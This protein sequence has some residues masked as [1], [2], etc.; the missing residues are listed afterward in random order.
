MPFTVSFDFV[1]G[2]KMMTELEGSLDMRTY[3]FEFVKRSIPLICDTN[4]IVLPG[5]FI[6]MEAIMERIPYDL[7]DANAVVKLIIN[8]GNGM[9]QTSRLA[10]RGG[11][12][13]LN[14]HNHSSNNELHIWKGKLL[15]IVDLRSLGYAHLSQEMIY[16]LLE[17]RFVMYNDQGKVMTASVISDLKEEDEEDLENS[18]III[19]PK[20]QELIESTKQEQARR[21]EL[22]K[23]EGDK[24]PWLDEDDPR[25][26][27]TD[28]EIIIQYINLDDSRLTELEKKRF[29][30]ILLKY[31]EAFSLRDEIGLC[32]NMEIKLRM[33]DKTPFF[34]RPFPITED[35]KVIVD[36]EMR[37]G[38]ML[39]IL[40]KGLSSY[41][42][43]IMLIP[44]KL[45]GTPR[46]VTD[47]RHLN[48]RLTRLNCTFP[49]VRDAIQMLGSS[50]CEVVSVIDLRDAYHT[51]RLAKDSQQYCGITPY[52][53][54]DT[55]IYQRLGMGLNVSPAI[56]QTFINQVLDEIED[57]KHHLAIMDDCMIHS[58]KKTHIKHLVNLFKALIRNGLKI[59]P[60]KCQFFKTE[61]V[62]MGQQLLIRDKTPCI[63]PLR[64]RVEA[65]QRVEAPTTVKGCRSFCG[66][67]NYLS[68]YLPNLQKRLIPIYQLTRKGVPYLWTEECQKAFEGIKQDLM[69][70]PVLV[71]PNNRDPFC[72]VSDTSIEAAGAA[73][74]QKQNEV[75]KLVGYNSKKLPGA[76]ARYSI[77]ELELM[78]LAINVHS[79]KHLLK[80]TCFMVIIDHSALTYI[81]K[82]K[83]EPPTLRLKKLIEILMGFSFNVYFM[84]GKDMHVSDFLSRHPGDDK[85]PDNEIIPISFSMEEV[86]TNRQ[87]L[88]RIKAILADPKALEDVFMTALPMTLRSRGPGAKIYPLQGDKRKPEHTPLVLDTSKDGNTPN[89]V[90]PEKTGQELIEKMI[91]FEDEV[92]EKR[93]DLVIRREPVEADKVPDLP[94]APPMPPLPEEPSTKDEQPP[95]AALPQGQDA[96]PYAPP[97]AREEAEELV[98]KEQAKNGQQSS[99]KEPRPIDIRLVGHLPYPN[100]YEDLED[101]PYVRDPDPYMYRKCKSL[102]ENIRDED[103][104]R[105]HIPKQMELDKWMEKLKRKVLHSYQLPITLVELI[106]EYSDSPRFRDYYKYLTKDFIPSGI[107]G[108]ALKK[109]KAKCEDF[110]IIQG[111]MFHLIPGKGKDE[112]PKLL[113]VIPERVVPIIFYQYHDSILAGHQGLQRTY[114]TLKQLYYIHDL[115]QLLRKYIQACHVCQ[116]RRPAPDMPKA[117]Y[118]RYPINCRPMS[119]I[120]ADLKWMPQSAQLM[121]YILVCT[122]E[123]TGY[124]I[125][126]PLR[127]GKAVTIAEALLNRVVYIFGPPSTLIIDQD[128]ALSADVMLNL[129]RILDINTRV[130]SPGNH[131]SL[132]TERSIRSI[133]DIVSKYLTGLGKNWP[134]YVAAACYAHNTFVNP[135]IGYSPY[136]LV[137]MHKPAPLTSIYHDPLED[138][139]STPN[140]AEFVTI[141]K[142]RFEVMKEVM[143]TQRTLQQ[144]Q[145]VERQRLE[146]PTIPNFKV[147]D[148]VYLYA[149]GYGALVFPSRKI[150]QD[151][152]GPLQIAAVIDKTHYWLADKEGKL[153]PFLHTTVHVRDLKPCY[154]HI[155]GSDKK[156]IATISNAKDFIHEKRRF[157][158][159]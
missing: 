41:S 7:H 97:P 49:L 29:R 147:G 103:I 121:Q 150:R 79:F 47:F 88:F 120:S 38:V 43:P 34:I 111:L 135:Q 40:R 60:K 35:E 153:L 117:E 93:P 5:K 71:M 148:L 155:P 22:M 63:T 37:K 54:S 31:R 65:L 123:L 85:C 143:Q 84:K 59:S 145:Q 102:L 86:I 98:E 116:T 56:W 32:P 77:S 24:Y 15:G 18:K 139:P 94:P 109:F 69:N 27:L 127:D 68:M 61:L 6:K 3:Q 72:L 83:K 10:L 125:G 156:E 39:G 4:G 100:D 23:H 122:C 101:K 140:V 78:G 45:G 8:R 107:K 159:P 151:Y 146:H 90:Q 67:V 55:Y 64:T 1:V 57:R 82:S 126:V 108:Y 157:E 12:V 92:A 30:K 130:I 26:K 95:P 21:K 17:K 134:L 16:R 142:Q 149:P 25:R 81:L 89:T 144:E 91:E 11:R 14:Y 20:T 132:K 75:W 62:Y 158:P 113:L 119:R 76:A 9:L 53:G 87:K 128:R 136:E 129:Y 70:P 48:S 99:E 124:V 66:M 105:K 58:E 137:F 138:Y 133:S 50:K 106:Q 96:V 36:K 115:F 114:A 74:Y 44:R 28:K 13:H 154:L 42:S 51:L 110:V 80:H 112:I 2:A 46:I 118:K 131:G 33:K 19:K 141:L 104:I 52:Y 73:L 152:I